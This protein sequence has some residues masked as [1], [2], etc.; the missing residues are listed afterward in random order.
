MAV[1]AQQVKELRES[2]GLPMMDC[3][4]ALEES[5]GDA[6]K[7][8]EVLRKRGMKVADKK[9]SRATAEGV[10]GS[11]VHHNNKLAVLLEVNCETDFVAR[12]DDFKNFVKDVCMHIAWARPMC[13]RRDELD[14]ALVEKEREI[15]AAQL[16]NVPEE[17]RA[18]AV[19]GKLE[20]SLYALKVLLDQPFCKDDSK[21]VEQ[22][23]KELIGK[24]RENIVIRRFVRMDLTE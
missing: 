12:G 14:P 11:Y 5:N 17:K 1:S 13:V 4:R 18:R 21:T 23:L 8:V 20:K 10:I 7:A 2:T 22:V 24:L 3:K 19:E 6:T 9:A 16:I 15:V